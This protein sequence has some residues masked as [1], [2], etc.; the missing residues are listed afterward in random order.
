MARTHTHRPAKSGWRW[1]S[2]PISDT[3]LRWSPRSF[4]AA[5]SRSRANNLAL[6]R[7]RPENGFVLDVL[8]QR[9]TRCAA[10]HEEAVEIRRHAAARDDH[11]QA[12]FVRPCE[13]EDGL[14]RRT[15]P[16]QSS[17]QSG[18]DFSS[19][20]AAT[21]ADHEGFQIVR[22]CS[23]VSVSSRSI[24]SRTFSTSPIPE[25]S[26]PTSVV[27]RA[28]EPL[29]LGAKSPRQ[30]ESRTEKRLLRLGGRLS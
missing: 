28:S 22:S 10:A 27:L 21:Q 20:D 2:G 11:G 1:P 30:A 8:I 23:T 16:A 5:P 17:Y 7:C 6:A 19:A 25:P 26:P 15:S 24:R 4:A 14:S 9:R 29:R 13:G 18:R 12:P 3:A